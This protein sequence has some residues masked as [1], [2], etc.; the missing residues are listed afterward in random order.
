M[1]NITLV[2]GNPSKVSEAERAL[3][4]QIHHIDLDLDEIQELNSDKI[5]EHKV[6]QAWEQ[7][8]QPVV[9]WDT[10]LYIDCLNGFPGPLIKWFYKQVGPEKICQIAKHLG[11]RGITAKSIVTFYDGQ[12]LKHFYGETKGQIPDEPRGGGGFGWDAI[13]IAEGS[14][15]TWAEMSPEDPLFHN[16]NTVPFQQLKDFFSLQ[17]PA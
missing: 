10:S 1:M 7:V 3:G 4:L 14:D 9:T 6:M 8:R 15:Q 13:F 17:N 2:T 16:V 12:T 11:D 5:A